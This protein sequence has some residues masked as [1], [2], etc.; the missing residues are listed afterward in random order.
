MNL[1]AA[2]LTVL[3]GYAG[4]GLLFSLLFV[5]VGL[6]RVDPVARGSSPAF[7][8]LIL[9]GV[10]ALWPLLLARWLRGSGQTS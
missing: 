1:I 2:L 3:A 9:P 6:V 4:L 10:A 8:I 7:R 5:T